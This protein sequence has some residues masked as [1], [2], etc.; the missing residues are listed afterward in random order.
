[1]DSSSGGGGGKINIGQLFKKSGNQI[2]N[3]FGE[4]VG[5]NNAYMP[6]W[7]QNELNYRG[8][9]DPLR[10]QHQQDLQNQFGPTQ[11]AQMLSAFK[12]LDPT[13]YSNREQLGNRLS[14]D[15]ANGTPYT[16][17]ANSFLGSLQSDFAKGTKLDP[18][19]ERQLKQ[20]I[21][22]SQ[23]ARGNTAGSAAGIAEAYTLGNAGLQLYQQRLGNLASGLGEASQ[24][25]QMPYSNMMN[26]LSQPTMATQAAA[27]PPVQADRSFAYENPNA[28]WQDVNAGM[29]MFQNILGANAINQQQGGNPWMS[30]IG[31][32]GQVAG[33]ILGSVAFSDR[34]LKTNIKR[35]G[36]AP[37]GSGIFEYNLKGPRFRGPI[38]QDVEKH[39]PWAV[40]T[41]PVS[42]YKMVALHRTDVPMTR[43]G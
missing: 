15:L 7:L 40:Q 3:L 27:I 1:M 16:N 41:D 36:T 12:S 14:G 23:A 24:I 6:M 5:L 37:S 28:G 18:G 34:R 17:A 29:G 30:A 38:A 32:I 43:I 21:R 25:G 35:V 9:Q 8:S 33:P 22:G 2:G 4:G 20:D 31:Q 39:T 10:I 42:K 26:F 11:Y 13:F 19:Q